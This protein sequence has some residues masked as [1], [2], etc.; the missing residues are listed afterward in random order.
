MFGKHLHFA[1]ARRLGSIPLALLLV[2]GGFSAPLVASRI[3]EIEENSPVKNRTEEISH[4]NR[5]SLQ[6]TLRAD[7]GGITTALLL[8]GRASLGNTQ[9][10]VLSS[11][12]GHRMP[13]GLLAPLTC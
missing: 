13:N 1:A 11:P 7:A 4:S 12:R 9:N 2:F 8:P 10:P 5:V 6:K 3:S